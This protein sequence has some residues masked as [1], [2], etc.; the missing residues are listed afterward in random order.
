MFVD[1]PL[2]PMGCSVTKGPLSLVPQTEWHWEFVL[3]GG[4][5]IRDQTDMSPV[6]RSE[7]T[8]RGK[9]SRVAAKAGD[10]WMQARGIPTNW[11]S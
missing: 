8:E 6:V 4:I 9:E 10:I 11:P 3:R 2:G 1:L 5:E 7:G